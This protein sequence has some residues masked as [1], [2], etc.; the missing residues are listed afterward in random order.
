MLIKVTQK[1][2]EDARKGTLLS[3]EESTCCP[4]ALALFEQVYGGTYKVKY[5]GTWRKRNYKIHFY[6]SKAKYAVNNPFSVANT[7]FV[8]GFFFDVNSY[9]MLHMKL[10]EQTKQFVIDFDKGKE[11]KPFEFECNLKV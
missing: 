9:K 11:V 4:I 8:N 10:T 6:H 5:R 1:H 2:I 3:V 7:I